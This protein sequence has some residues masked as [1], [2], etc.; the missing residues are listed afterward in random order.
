MRRGLTAIALL[1]IALAG[2]PA[3]AQGLADRLEL[4]RAASRAQ[5][6][7][8]RDAQLAS[9]R[10]RAE[11]RDQAVVIRGNVATAGERARAEQVAREAA[12]ALRIVNEIEVTAE[13][14]RAAGPLPPR[15]RPAEPPADPPR[16]AAAAQPAAV[17]H[18]VR[19]GDTLFAIARRHNTTVAEIQRLNGLRGTNIRPGQRLRVR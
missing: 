13:A 8:A 9:Y 6:A 19:S 2:P 5:V 12:G 3:A 16:T 10:L 14:R 17:Y 11:L 1:A 7:L 18:T 15:V 4:S